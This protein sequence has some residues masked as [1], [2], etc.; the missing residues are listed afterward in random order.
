MFV[1]IKYQPLLGLT[2]KMTSIFIFSV[3][4]P[5]A[6]KIGIERIVAVSFTM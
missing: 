6:V 4:L 1:N 2:W 5:D 3:T